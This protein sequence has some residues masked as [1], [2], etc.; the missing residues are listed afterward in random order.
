MPEPG[1]TPSVTVVIPTR[2]RAEILQRTLGGALAQEG[3]DHDVIVVDDGSRDG[4]AA[5]VEGLGDPRVRV[6]RHEESRG[7]A[8]ARNAGIREARGEW[9][10]FLDDDD[11]WA[12]DKLRTQID[13]ARST[14]AAVAY[15]AVA[16]VDEHL[17][18][19]EVLHGPDPTD[20]REELITG[21]VIPAGCSNVVATAEI[22]RQV[23]GFDPNLHQFADWD[24]WLR[25]T[26]IGEAAVCKQPLVAYVQHSGSMMLA[27]DF[28][29]LVVEFEYIAD[30]HRG[31]SAE[32]G[33]EF[34][35][36]GLERWMA[37]GESRSGRRIP[38]T[39]RYLRAALM[40]GRARDGGMTWR[41]LRHAG[42]ALLGERLTDSGAIPLSEGDRGP[43]WLDRYR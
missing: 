24:M 3:V 29:D 32:R 40:Y 9:L 19:I 41:S 16:V 38:A 12:P 8:A 23:D 36:G 28:H 7:V 35:R 13:G 27:N 21:C 11:L 43:A 2:D 10:A 22:V 34:D 18:V 17:D 25:L 30:K 1:Q 26:A 31:L 6:L 15:A 37:W 33:I 39:R 14:G 4:T 20:V 5:R 42:G